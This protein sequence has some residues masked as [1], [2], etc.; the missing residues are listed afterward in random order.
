MKLEKIQEI[1]QAKVIVGSEHL[2]QE[3]TTAGGSDMM[4]DVLSFMK[5]GSLLLTGLINP[6]SVRTAEIAEILAICYVRSKQPLPE[7]VTLAN[8]KGIPLL[9]THFTMYEACGKLY[10]GGLPGRTVH[11]ED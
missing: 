3:V 8:E 6:Q 4:S 7:T 1:L 10:Q 9:S 5:P 2:Q 11:K